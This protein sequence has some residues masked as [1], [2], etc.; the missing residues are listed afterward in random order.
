MHS[1]TVGWVDFGLF[2]FEIYVKFCVFWDSW[3]LYCEKQNFG[4][5]YSAWPKMFWPTVE[6][7]LGQNTFF[8]YF[9]YFWRVCNKP[10]GYFCPSSNINPHYWTVQYWKAWRPDRWKKRCINLAKKPIGA[11]HLWNLIRTTKLRVLRFTF[12]WFLKGDRLT[13]KNQFKE[14]VSKNFLF[15]D[16]EKKITDNSLWATTL[17]PSCKVILN[18]AYHGVCTCCC[19][20]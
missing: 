10:Q 7:S 11:A 8:V 5:L 20:W 13:K 6:W 1:C 19:V 3:S 16:R 12:N 14:R 2:Y 4:P 15:W 9:R 18:S 17:M